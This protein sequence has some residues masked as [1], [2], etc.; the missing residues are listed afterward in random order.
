MKEVST[1]GANLKRARNDR[2]LS[3]EGL[4]DKA[5]LSKDLI[6]KLEQGRRT[7]CRMTSLMKLANALDVDLADLTGKRERLGTDRDGGSVLAIR[8]AILAP[9]LMPGLSGL[10]ADDDGNPTPL[11]ELS[12]AVSRSWKD[13][14]AGDFGPLVAAMPGLITEAR[15]THRSEGPAA[16]TAMAQSYQLAACLLLH[17]GKTDLAAISAERGLQAASQGT[18]EWQWASVVSTLAWVLMYQ[19]RLT[20]SENLA[21]DVAA[22][23]E[24]SFSSPA[25]HLASWGNLLIAAIDTAAIAGRD[26]SEYVSM[27]AAGAERL[28]GLVSA[29]QT[30]FGA[31]KVAAN[32]VHAYTM[33]K[34]PGEALKTARRVRVEEL[35]RIAYGHHL[36]DLAQAHT[37]AHHL[38]T[39]EARLEE[40]S[41]L[42]PV[43][44]RH[45]VTA[46]S[47]V[48][49][50]RE[51]QTRP[52][53]TIRRL[54]RA[55]NLD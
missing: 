24:P 51:Q 11:P 26:V 43:W 41:A 34:N 25:P 47:I 4:A 32:A 3:Q 8:D 37:D 45:Q 48:A 10:D 23:I 15:L 7:S 14:W 40:A 16:T 30:T 6:G 12:A 28:G 52:S 39:A 27:A 17:L 9:S 31:S 29:Y 1:I 19:G 33:Q 50:I 2:G 21:A 13:Y 42:S 55:V 20:E 53:P 49:D 22:R 18:D 38:H 36:I 35:P 46:Q 44:F 5:Q 54:A